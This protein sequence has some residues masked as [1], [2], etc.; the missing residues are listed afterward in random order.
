MHQ[1]FTRRATIRMAAGLGMAAGIGTARQARAGQPLRL[2]VALSMSGRFSDSARYLREGYEFWAAEVNGKGGLAGTPVELIVYDDESSPDTGRVLAERLI[3]RDG[4]SVLL[5]PYS[6]PI[7][8]AVATACERAQVP[9]IATMASDPTVWDRR[10]LGWT[11]QAFPSSAYDH[12]AFLAVATKHAAPGG[13]L[14]IVY[15]ESPFSVQAQAWAL[16]RAKQTGLDAASFGYAPGAQ[17]FSSIV[18]RIIA[19]NAAMLSMGGYFQPAVSLT[20]QLIDRSYNLAGY[21]FI[22]AADDVTKDSLAGNADGIFGRTAWEPTTGDPAGAAF[23]A[24][25]TAKYKH[26]PTYHSAAAYSGGQLIAAAVEAKGADKAGMRAFLGSQQVRTLLGTYKV[27]AR[28][29]QEGYRYELAQWQG[30]DRK[31]V[32]GEGASPAIWPKPK[33]V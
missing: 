6:S 31:L 24:A 22:L 3:G 7:T 2:G 11:F 1:L 12:E 33:W 19:S 5:G 13:K 17:D 20:R 28:G 4:A 14:A 8:D 25:Y 29:Q 30:G 10:K 26:A 32:S 27:N 9:M 15:E 23:A 16:D 21:H 18:E